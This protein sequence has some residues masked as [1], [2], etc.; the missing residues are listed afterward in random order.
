MI[1]GQDLRWIVKLELDTRIGL[2]I[3]P[4]KRNF[5]G[6]DSIAS[7]ANLQLGALDVYLSPIVIGSTVEGD[8]FYSEQII[9]IGQRLRN[10]CA[11]CLRTCR[12]PEL[13]IQLLLLSNDGQTLR[14][15][16]QARFRVDSWLIGSNLEPYFSTTIP[17][18]D[19]LAGRHLG[20]IELKRAR[21]SDSSFSKEANCR[22]SSYSGNGCIRWKWLFTTTS[23]SLYIYVC[24]TSMRPVAFGHARI[25]IVASLLP[26]NDEVGECVCR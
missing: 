20:H 10:L 9:S 21:M 17:T 3:C 4:G 1:A 24:L 2:R 7:P 14:R 6:W 16:I 23:H 22:S 15:K 13:V 26:V 19:F 11:H 18:R 5:W 25:L 8:V 12:H